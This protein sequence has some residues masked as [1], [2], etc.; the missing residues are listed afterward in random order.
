MTLS[1]AVA[2]YPQVANTA[3]VNSRREIRFFKGIADVNAEAL[4]SQL[5]MK[6]EE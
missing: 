6:N 3:N 2:K 4:P 1:W 5:K